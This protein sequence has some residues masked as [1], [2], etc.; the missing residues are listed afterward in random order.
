MTQPKIPP[1]ITKQ[2]FALPEGLN[3]RQAALLGLSVTAAVLVAFAVQGPLALRAF[4]A[5][6]I[7]GTGLALAFKTIQ[8]ESLEV[9]LFRTLMF[10]LGKRR[11][12]IWR[13]GAVP[14]SRTL[15]ET[16]QASPAQAIAPLPSVRWRRPVEPQVVHDLSFL[17]AMANVLIFAILAGLSVYMATGGAQQLLT[18]LDFMA[19]R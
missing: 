8:G 4:L 18:Y 2:D 10:N 16:S 14:T 12:M 17:G 9:W 5:V 19:G 3:L 1:R 7:A 6:L 11:L 15:E 13:R